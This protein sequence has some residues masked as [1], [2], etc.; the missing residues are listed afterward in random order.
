MITCQYER[1]RENL[2]FTRTIII[3][4]VSIYVIISKLRNVC[5]VVYPGSVAAVIGCPVGCSLSVR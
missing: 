4:E 2:E 3:L 5:F 1:Y